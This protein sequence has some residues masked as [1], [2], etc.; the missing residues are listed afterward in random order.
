M[1]IRP[2]T[3]SDQHATKQ[4]ILDGLAEYWGEID[5]T[6][7]PDL[8]QIE[9]SYREGYF[10]VAEKN[11]VIIG[12]GALIPKDDQSG[13]I[14][15]MSVD[16]KIRRAGIGRKILDELVR[17]AI[18]TGFTSIILETT[19]TWEDAIAF[20]KSYG[21]QPTYEKDGDQYFVYHLNK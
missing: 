14:V 9:D 11:G 8:N 21:F 20:Y 16:S 3:P 5:P 4:L 18:T 15:R 2:F 13:Q 10:V 19:I 6:L 7:N 17:Y 12:C 1:I